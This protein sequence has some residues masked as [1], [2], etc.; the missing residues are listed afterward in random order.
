[1]LFP[2]LP[3]KTCVSLDG[4]G[5]VALTGVGA[6]IRLDAVGARVALSLAAP[7]APVFPGT[8]AVADVPGAVRLI[9]ARL[10]A[11]S[12][13]SRAGRLRDAPPAVRA[14]LTAGLRLEPG[15]VPPPRPAAPRAGFVSTGGL[16]A[17]LLAL[18]YGRCPADALARIAAW[19]RDQGFGEVRASPGRALAIPG[20]AP[21]KAPALLREAAGLG[22]IVDPRD[23]RLSVSACPGA[24]ACAS[25]ATAA[26]ADADVLAVA[27]RALLAGGMTLHVSGC[28][29]GC[30]HPGPA[31]LT[32]VGHEGAY[33]VVLDGSAGDKP[34]A[35]LRPDDLIETL[36]G[37]RDSAGL[38]SLFTKPT[39]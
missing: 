5:L 1:M 31:G 13:S 10:A 15:S 19:S 33:A 12:G 9:L 35:H 36:R 25:G 4:G 29:K 2:E 37:A 30:A 22:F 28:A 7:D 8:L 20:I 34:V 6:D 38:A 14:A 23:P 27:A 17:L 39:P 21:S 18:P 3:P 32:L 16:Y 26:R 11:W 24:P